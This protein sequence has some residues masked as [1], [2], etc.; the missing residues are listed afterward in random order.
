MPSGRPDSETNDRAE[1]PSAD[2]PTTIDRSDT[3]STDRSD[4]APA[5]QSTSFAKPS[6]RRWDVTGRVGNI[7]DEIRQ[8]GLMLGL[9]LMLAGLAMYGS[10]SYDLLAAA[11]I[12]ALAVFLFTI[13]FPFYLF[14][15][16]ERELYVYNGGD[17]HIT[18]EITVRPTAARGDVTKHQVSLP[19]GEG[20]EL[21]VSVNPGERYTVSATVG[22]EEFSTEVVPVRQSAPEADRTDLR[23]ELDTT[24]IR[25]V[26]YAS[27]HAPI[28]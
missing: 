13:S 18:T 5:G 19:P 9:V 28:G 16:D 22:G 1:S 15:E 2:D 17:D 20:T 10:D 6:E 26:R 24:K 4:T 25:G 12:F 23:I 27:G 3:T 8:A 14:R 21:T 7:W 11:T